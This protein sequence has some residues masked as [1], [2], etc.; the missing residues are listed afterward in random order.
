MFVDRAIIRVKAGD[1][2]HG[3]LSFRREKY[4][5]YGGPDGGDG[6]RGGDVI[7]RADARLNTLFEFRHRRLLKAARG[8][9][10]QGSNKRGADGEDLIV[11]VP[12]GTLVYDDETGA[13]LADLVEDGAEAVVAKG[14]RGGRGNARFVSSV[15]QAPRIAERGE[16]GEE[17]VIRLELK[18]L[19]D[20]GL[21]GFPN[22]GKSTLLSVVSAARPKVADYP[23][24]TLTPHLGVVGWSGGSFVMADIP[25]LIEG[26]HQGAGLGDEFLRHVERCRLLLHL[27]DAAATEGRDPVDAL[28]AI[29]AELRA[30]RA[31]LAERPQWIVATKA[32]IPDAEDGIR[33]LKAEAERLGRRFFSISAVT[34][35]GVR[36]L[37]EAAG[38]ALLELPK[39]NVAPEQPFVLR[40]VDDE[41]AI[42]VERLDDGTW[43]V[44]GRRVERAVAMTD[45]DNREAL[46]YLQRRLE[47]WGVESALKKAGAQ[48]GDTVRIG[49]WEFVWE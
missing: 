5:P 35:R 46:L 13:L 45:L 33:R 21:V 24:T 3:A 36:E 22:A 4:V 6:G 32:D 15:R 8:R 27:V 14:G 11:P 18:L 39:P 31:E 44:R 19:A 49:A 30:Y 34:G 25:G 12:V 28:H 9:N 38:Q 7:L 17:R 40:D 2:G 29:D 10:G 20:V 41:T 1:G 43:V 48:P 37:V 26:A 16:P 47:R 23:F 42:F